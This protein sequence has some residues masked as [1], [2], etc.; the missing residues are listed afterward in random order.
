M[1]NPDI[2][3]FTKVA[4]KHSTFKDKGKPNRGYNDDS[5]NNQSDT[6]KSIGATGRKP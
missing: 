6:D 1:I 5:Y 2:E 4:E 3:Q